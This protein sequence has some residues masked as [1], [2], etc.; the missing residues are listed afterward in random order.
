MNFLRGPMD[1]VWLIETAVTE[2]ERGHFGRIFCEREFREHGLPT[3]FVQSSLSY[4]RTKGTT[5]GLH[6]QWPPSQE[7]KAVRCVRGAVYDVIVDL[8]PGS[9]TFARSH[10]AVLSAA[11][12]NGVYFPPGFAHGFQ[13]LEDDTEVLYEMTDYFEPGLAHGYPIDDPAF[14]VTWPDVPSVISDRDRLLS[15]FDAERHCAAWTNRQK[16]A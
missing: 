16:G 15:R 4:N 2:D 1:G 3:R 6:F 5:R 9:P 14:D 7:G 12:C 8:R 13:S 11:L 10:G